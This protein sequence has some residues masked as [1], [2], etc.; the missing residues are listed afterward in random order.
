[1][2]GAREG[3]RRREGSRRELGRE[4]GIEGEAGRPGGRQ[5]SIKSEGAARYLS[6]QVEVK[7]IHKVASLLLH[8]VDVALSVLNLLESWECRRE[9]RVKFDLL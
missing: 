1:M 5:G 7:C 4:G 2:E 3:G 6:E 9:L 8:L